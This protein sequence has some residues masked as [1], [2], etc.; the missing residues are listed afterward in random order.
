MREGVLVAQ[1]DGAAGAFGP[2]QLGLAVRHASAGVQA[3]DMVYAARR[4][5]LAQ[6]RTLFDVL[7]EDSAV[8][9]APGDRLG[10]L[11]D[12]T[13]YLGPPV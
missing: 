7:W 8:A 6:N 12:P 9:K 13:N 1:L 4:V 11:G 5:A 2:G 10:T 3:D